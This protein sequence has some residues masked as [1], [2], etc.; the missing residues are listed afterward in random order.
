MKFGKARSLV[1]NV[2]LM[3]IISILKDHPGETLRRPVHAGKLRGTSDK[4]ELRGQ[5]LEL[6]VWRLLEV[7][8]SVIKT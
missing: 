5:Q 4:L 1:F 3:I 2:F 6:H 8:C 7:S